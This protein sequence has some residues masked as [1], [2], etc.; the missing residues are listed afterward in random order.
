MTPGLHQ[1]VVAPL[2]RHASWVVVLAVA[3]GGAGLS[4][5]GIVRAVKHVT[6]VVEGN[7]GII[8]TF[9]EK[10]KASTG[11]TFAATYVT[12]GNS[13]TTVVYAVKPPKGLAFQSLPSQLNDSNGGDVSFIVN[14]AGEYSC[15]KAS[16]SARWSCEKLDPATAIVKKQIFGL[17][18]PSHWIAFLKG[19]AL[20]AGFAGDKVTT[21]SMTVNGFAMSCVDFVAP[22]VKGTSTICTT[23]QGILGYVKVAS[24]KTSFEIKS[25]TTSPSASLFALPPGA[26]IS[27]VSNGG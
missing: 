22:G 11:T 20:A 2:R 1:A 3:L 24:T 12:T 4:G 15:D 26:K 7:R 27:D 23:S 5:C 8:N 13:P 25:Y 21:S 10:L 17:Y 19:F 18:T 14:S 9:T 16:A 6:H